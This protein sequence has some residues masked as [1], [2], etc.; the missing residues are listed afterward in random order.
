M[1]NTDMEMNTLSSCDKLVQCFTQWSVFRAWNLDNSTFIGH[2]PFLWHH[3]PSWSWVLF[4]SQLLNLFS[5]TGEV[6]DIVE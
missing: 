5:T 1:E 4:P 3:T 2:F 6:T